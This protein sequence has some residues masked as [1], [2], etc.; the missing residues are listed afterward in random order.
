MIP[1]FDAVIYCH[2]LGIVHRDLKPENLLLDSKDLDKATIKISDFGLSRCLG[3]AELATTTAGTPG[4]VAPEVLSQTPYDYRCDYWSLGVVLFLML[5]GTP[6]F[7]HPDHLELFE[8]IKK[9]EFNFGARTWENVSD[10]AKDLIKGL[11]VVNPEERFTAE[12]I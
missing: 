2:G 12:Q 10:E 3:K 9:G 4:Y 7:Y 6:P 1:L 5:S 8:M 11:L